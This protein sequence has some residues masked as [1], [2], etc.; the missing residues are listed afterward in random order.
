ILY[1]EL[2]DFDGWFLI[3]K[4]IKKIIAKIESTGQK[5]GNKFEIRNGFA[6]LKNNVYV[7]TPTG[8]NDEFYFMSKDK[9]EYKIEKSICREA[10]KPN[11]LKL[12]SE[13]ENQ[14]EKLIFP[15]LIENLDTNLFKEKKQTLKIIDEKTLKSKYSN[16]Y[17]YLKTQKEI[18]SKR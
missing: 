6:T 2:N 3:D 9:I 10:I 4:K 8:Q 17:K 13:I 12:A 11:T 14:T 1:S 16:T 15:Y 7:F 18:L 5:L